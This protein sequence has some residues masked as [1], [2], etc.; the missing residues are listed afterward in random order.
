MAEAAKWHTAKIR[1]EDATLVIP[2]LKKK[3]V[4]IN[5]VSDAELARFRE[6]VAP[7]HKKWREKV[8]PALYDEATAF[9]KN[10]RK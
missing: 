7:V 5:Q 10:H 8:G 6:A 9:L 2:D 1:E 3:G 4:I